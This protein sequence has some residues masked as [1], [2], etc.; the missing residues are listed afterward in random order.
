MQHGEGMDQADPSKV[1][2][3]V[4][5]FLTPTGDHNGGATAFVHDQGTEGDP[6][7]GT[8]S[9]PAPSVDFHG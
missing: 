2:C 4:F 9:N 5:L 8:F 7:V 6:G 1:E 3:L